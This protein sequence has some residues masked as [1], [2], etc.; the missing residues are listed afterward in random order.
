M[1]IISSLTFYLFCHACVFFACLPEC[2]CISVWVCVFGSCLCFIL[3]FQNVSTF[4][5]DNS[6]LHAPRTCRL[7]RAR[8]TNAAGSPER[9]PRE[10]TKT[11]SPDSL[12]V[13]QSP[14]QL[15][16]RCSVNYLC[17][18]CCCC[19]KFLWQQLPHPAP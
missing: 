13:C 12:P 19:F 14:S 10:S 8:A 17:I 11:G 18:C 6:T 4:A 16:S 3:L 2:V 7:R 5:A 9:Q 1:S 15:V